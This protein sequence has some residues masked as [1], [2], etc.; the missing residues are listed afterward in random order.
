VRSFVLPLL[1]V[2][3][4]NETNLNPEIYFWLPCD[5]YEDK[6]PYIFTAVIGVIPFKLR[7]SL[8]FV[9]RDR[10]GLPQQDMQC[11]YNI[12]LRC[13][14]ASIVAVEKQWALHNLSVCICSLSCPA[15]NAHAPYCHL[16]P[17]P[18]PY[19]FPHY[20]TNGTIFETTFTEHKN[21][22]S[23]FSTTFV[24]RIIERDII[25]HVY[26]SSYFFILVRF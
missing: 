13:V 6:L 26:W 1:T 3:N 23:I 12:T 10:N 17:A 21:C 2:A 8:C 22:V 20:L 18:L 9:L 5:I 15:C 14:R 7:G 4:C 25:K 24:L 11:T 16:W 19:I